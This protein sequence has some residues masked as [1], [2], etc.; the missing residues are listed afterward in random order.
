MLE[1]GGFIQ[2]FNTQISRLPNDFIGC[3]VLSNDNEHGMQIGEVIK[4]YIYDRALGLDTID[5]DSRYKAI[6]SVAP[7]KASVLATK[8]Q[9][10]SLNFTDFVGSYMNPGYGQLDFCLI[11]PAPAN[12]SDAC[13]AL[14]ANLTTILPGAFTNSTPTLLAQYDS[15]WFSHM[16]LEHFDN[17]VWNISLISSTPTTGNDTASGPFW[18][19]NPRPAGSDQVA[20][21]EFDIADEQIGLGMTGVWQG[22]LGGGI[23]PTS[24]DTVRERAEVYWDKI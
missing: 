7:I 15:P 6:K 18:A 21:A 3:A 1:H 22:I 16:K 4:N 23:P 9:E 14:S 17:N 13:Q 10:P 12:A 8:A 2:G 19:Y 24:G 20:V 11:N 5:W